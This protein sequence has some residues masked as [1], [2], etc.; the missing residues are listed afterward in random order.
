MEKPWLWDVVKQAVG[1][2]GV[3]LV[4]F[5]VLKPIMRSLA[6]KGSQAIDANALLTATTAAAGE[7]AGVA[8]RRRIR[9]AG[10]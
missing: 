8:T 5:G 6:E 9:S 3:L 4:I 7:A 1:A 10:C 2:L